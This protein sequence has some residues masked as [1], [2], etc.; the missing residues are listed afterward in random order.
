MFLSKNNES[1]KKKGNATSVINNYL[2]TFNDTGNKPIKSTHKILHSN[3]PNGIRLTQLSYLL[4]K[5]LSN[6]NLI[7][8]NVRK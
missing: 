1:N 8:T 5:I 3:D 6:D 7:Y 2:Y 4:M